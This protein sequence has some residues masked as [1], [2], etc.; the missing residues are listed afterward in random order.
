[1]STRCPYCKSASITLLA[2]NARCNDC[3]EDI[4]YFDLDLESDS[5]VD[6]YAQELREHKAA[7]I[8]TLAVQAI[9]SSRFYGNSRAYRIMEWAQR[10]YNTDHT[11]KYDVLIGFHRVQNL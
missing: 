8:M 11:L 7:Y 10:R 3:D 4:E 5:I 1:M 6:A 2:E 9:E